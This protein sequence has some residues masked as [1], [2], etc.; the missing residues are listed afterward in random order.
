M[1][2][3]DVYQQYFAAKCEFSGVPRR[4]VSVMLTATSDSGE[5]RYEVTVSFF[6]H[7][8]EEDYAVSYDAVQTETVYA[9]KGR[10]S[11]K[12]EA[13]LMK[14]FRGTADALAE[15]LGAEIFWE[16]PLRDARLG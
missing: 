16:Q 4:A 3:I 15:K 14:T 13:E 11:K 8:D 7:R 10:R 6:P 1:K 12:R 5:I 2:V 9:A